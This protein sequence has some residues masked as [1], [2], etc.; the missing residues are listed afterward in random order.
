M[1][2]RWAG[3]PSAS[4][5]GRGRGRSAW[6]CEKPGPGD[7]RACPGGREERGEG[8]L[9]GGVGVAGAPGEC[10]RAWSV[11]AAPHCASC[12]PPSGKT[13]LG[14]GMQGVFPWPPSVSRYEPRQGAGGQLGESTGLLAST[15]ALPSPGLGERCDPLLLDGVG[16]LGGGSRLEIPGCVHH[17]RAP[18]V[19]RVVSSQRGWFRA[20]DHPRPLA[21]TRRAPLPEGPR[22]P[23]GSE[24]RAAPSGLLPLLLRRGTCFRQG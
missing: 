7:A 15:P 1:G 14:E 21:C 23:R 20:A 9:E 6:D 3:R 12:T 22:W 4:L 18:E 19:A 11:G 8:P 13:R 16:S 10:A 2:W 24:V 17:C 5:G